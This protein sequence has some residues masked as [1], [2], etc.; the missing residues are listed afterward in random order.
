MELVFTFSDLID[1][2]TAA[3]EGLVQMPFEEELPQQIAG[4]AVINTTLDQDSVMA[5]ELLHFMQEH[6]WRKLPAEQK[7][8]LAL[9]LMYARSIFQETLDD[10]RDCR[11]DTFHARLS[12]ISIAF[13]F[14]RIQGG[15]W[16]L[17]K[18]GVGEQLG[19]PWFPLK[20]ENGPTGSL[21]VKHIWD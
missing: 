12:I 20:P 6:E 10:G 14:W 8:N 3:I 7:I 11:V 5:M 16:L 9:R 15:Q 2:C 18:I 13:D 17:E 1:T 19:I 4:A 21:M